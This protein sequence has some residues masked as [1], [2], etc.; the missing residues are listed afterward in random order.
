MSEVDAREPVFCS[1]RGHG[2]MYR[3][4]LG[5]HSETATLG[6]IC[7]LLRSKYSKQ[8]IELSREVSYP[9]STGKCDIILSAGDG[10]KLAIE[11]KLLR[12]LGDNG[13]QNDHLLM[14]ILSPYPQDRSLLTDC[15]KLLIDRPADQIGVLIFGY[16][17]DD[18]LLEP[19]LEAFE[20]L[21]NR[22]CIVNRI[23]DLRV[24]RMI[25]PVHHTGRVVAWSVTD[26]AD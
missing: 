21:A 19:A 7:E 22:Q 11:A 8:D 16:E 2:R 13:K 26:L 18:W 15:K 12:F 9:N 17:S 4:G 23:A 6:L 25:H 24:D 5:P 3:P 20:V 1:N 14:H 10:E